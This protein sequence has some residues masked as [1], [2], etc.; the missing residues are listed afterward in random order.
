MCAESR[1]ACEIAPRRLLL[2]A[3]F[4]QPSNGYDCLVVI[5]R[6]RNFVKTL[7]AT[8]WGVSIHANRSPATSKRPQPSPSRA[9][10]WPE[11]QISNYQL[12]AGK[13]PRRRISPGPLRAPLIP[14]I[15]LTAQFRLLTSIEPSLQ[16]SSIL[17]GPG[18]H[19]VV[20]PHRNP[21]QWTPRSR[22][23]QVQFSEKIK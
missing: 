21:D 9:T 6:K 18:K 4:T 16:Q 22:R 20:M 23:R 3:A 12:V 11:Q 17:E 1:A 2:A 7:V 5:G 10:L 8:W 13:Q 15:A 19:Q 14:R